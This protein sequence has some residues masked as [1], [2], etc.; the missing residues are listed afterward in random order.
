MKE[1]LDKKALESE[2]TDV[3]EVVLLKSQLKE[4]E[5]LHASQRTQMEQL[6]EEM[7]C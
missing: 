5:L 4:T 1:L 6:Q 3:Y 7:T 2:V